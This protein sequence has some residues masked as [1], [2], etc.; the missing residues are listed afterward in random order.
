MKI[1]RNRGSPIWTL[2]YYNP[3]YADPLTIVTLNLGNPHVGRSTTTT[4]FSNERDDRRLDFHKDLRHFSK[5][6]RTLER[7]ASEF[8][9]SPTP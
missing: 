2:I 4:H 8:K 1:S 6:V 5:E 9:V 3:D 7:G